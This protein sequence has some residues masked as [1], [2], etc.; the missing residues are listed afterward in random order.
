MPPTGGIDVQ[1]NAT[2]SHLPRAIFQDIQPAG[3]KLWLTSSW[4]PTGIQLKYLRSLKEM[5]AP[6]ELV[7]KRPPRLSLAETKDPER[8]S[9]VRTGPPRPSLANSRPQPDSSAAST[10]ITHF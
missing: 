5:T 7:G 2:T 4:H 3:I 6:V 10:M 1:V 9:S 8:L